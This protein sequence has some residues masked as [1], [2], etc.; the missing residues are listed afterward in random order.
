MYAILFLFTSVLLSPV[1]GAAAVQNAASAVSQ[2][3]PAAEAQ[4]ATI[5]FRKVFKSSTPEFVELKIDERGSG[6][7]D[8][9]QLDE[10]PS[11]QPFQVETP[12]AAKI[13]SLAAELHD[14][15]GIQLEARRRIASLGV[16]TFG[17]EKGGETHEIA[18][19]YTLNPTANELLNLFEG[20]SLQQQY[21][22]ELKR[23]MRYDPLGLNDILLQLQ[24]DFSQKLLADPS[25]LLPLL[26]Q[27]G[28]DSRF[29]DIVRQRARSIADQIHV[30]H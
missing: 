26:D 29:M 28:S 23:S 22:D 9:R 15:D 8:I 7:Y 4:A 14:F 16:K 25:A 17:Y 6:T 18:F 19:N 1:A 24:G 12:L 21:V 13:F 5:T 3:P 11:P 27:I 2:S 20:V 30:S 10:K